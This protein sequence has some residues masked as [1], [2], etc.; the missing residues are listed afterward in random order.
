MISARLTTVGIG[1]GRKLMPPRELSHK[2]EEET[3]K[4]AAYM[5]T[6]LAFASALAVASPARAEE[7]QVSGTASITQVESHFIPDAGDPTR[8]SG[9]EKFVG[10]DT[11]PG[12][13]DA[14]QNRGG[15]ANSD[16]SLSGNSA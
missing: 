16:R 11:S 2:S 3:M 14:A 15:R 13:F 8:G 1:D 4:L 6:T 9:I 12:W 7:R 10:A 5:I